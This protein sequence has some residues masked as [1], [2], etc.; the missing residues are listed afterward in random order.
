MRI[1]DAVGGM[2]LIMVGTSAHAG[3]FLGADPGVLPTG[4][5]T[6]SNAAKVAFNFE[7]SSLGEVGSVDFGGMTGKVGIGGATTIAP[8][9][10]VQLSNVNGQLNNVGQIAPLTSKTLGFNTTAGQSVGDFLQ[11]NPSVPATPGTTTAYF[12][13]ENAIQGFGAHFTGLQGTSGP[14]YVVYNFEDG[15]TNEIVVTPDSGG[16]AN[17]VG[18]TSPGAR[19]ASVSVQLRSVQRPG[20]G[21]VYDVYGIDDLSFVFSPEFFQDQA[22]VSQVGVPVTTTL[23]DQGAPGELTVEFQS[24]SS[25]IVSVTYHSLADA[26]LPS[27]NIDPST[28]LLPGDLAQVWQV[29]MD[30][31]MFDPIEG[32]LL[33][34]RYDDVG[35]TPEEEEALA[36]YHYKNGS[37]VELLAPLA[38][39]TVN[40]LITVRTH[41]FSDFVLT[42]QLSS[43]VPE[44]GTGIT[45][46]VLGLSGCVIRRLRRPTKV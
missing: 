29:H 21:A 35:M 43:P 18:Y 8:G 9:V 12:A 22:T 10:T 46:L 39:D 42:N 33:T 2:I 27:L 24:E 40:N 20:I 45:F 31:E 7:A 23:L 4:T 5:L 44:P 32:V 3:V 6:N 38:L 41:S 19:I 34:M 13:F 11:I 25:G 17:Y 16:G 37:L 26:L 15:S 30:A 14:L 1:A 36:L 28:L